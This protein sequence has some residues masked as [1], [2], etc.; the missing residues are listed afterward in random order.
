MNQNQGENLQH[1]GDLKGHGGWVT[2]MVTGNSDHPD[3]LVSVSRD[4]SLLI[5]KM[6]TTVDQGE[7]SSVKGTTYRR[8]T[9]HSHFISDVVLSSDNNFALTSS[10]DT[11]MRLWDLR[12]GRTTYR[13]VGHSKDVLSVTMSPDNRQI[14]S[15]SRDKTIKLW[16][17]LAECK[18]DFEPQNS[19]SDWVT[20]VRFTPTTKDPMIITAG[21]DNLVKL[22]DQQTFKH[23]AD[24]KGHT[25]CVNTINVSPD[26]NFCA[27]GGKDC[28]AMIWQIK[29]NTLLYQLDTQS[30]INCLAFS[31]TRYWLAAATDDGIKVWDLDSKSLINEFT[32][33]VFGKDGQTKI[34]SP[35]A[36]SVAWSSNGDI[37]Y[38]G[39]TDGVIRAYAVTQN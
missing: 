25:G 32:P 14:I 1:V 24:L 12:A 38:G 29:D 17:T 10:W 9:G 27:S 23:K 16:N 22:W 7:I 28:M 34:K 31:P 8:L 13:F 18:Y 35:S 4:R 39:F 30:S 11:T 6:S 26:G 20:C 19:H 33:E 21:W 5:W 3:L 37:L 2:A 36:L 15:G